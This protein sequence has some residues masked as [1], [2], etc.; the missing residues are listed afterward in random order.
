MGYAAFSVA[1]TICRFTGDAVTTPLRAAAGAE[2][3]RRA[4]LCRFL[5]VAL[6]PS[7]LGRARRIHPR[8]DRCLEPRPR[9]LQWRRARTGVPPGIA[10]ATVTTIAYIGCCL[11]R[12]DWFVATQPAFRSRSCC[13]PR[14]SVSWRWQRPGSPDRWMLISRRIFR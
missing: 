2:G 7:T 13:R 4:R 14:C 1:M 12:P 9:S 11:A 6:L 10:L 5:A 8:R 3:R